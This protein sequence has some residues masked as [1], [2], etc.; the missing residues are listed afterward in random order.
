MTAEQKIAELL[1]R[2]E[3]LSPP[4]NVRFLLK[5][6]ADVERTLIPSNISNA[7]GL[8]YRKSSSSRPSVILNTRNHNS[9][10]ERFT[11]AH[12]LGHIILPWQTGT[13]YC[14]TDDSLPN[15]DLLYRD[16]EFEANRFAGELLVPV[17]WAL[18]VITRSDSL[19]EG[20]TKAAQR[21]DVSLLVATFSI[22]GALEN[23]VTYVTRNGETVLNLIG[24]GLG[25]W[26][27]KNWSEALGR[28][29]ASHGMQC[30]KADFGAYTL[31]C[32]AFAKKIARRRPSLSSVEILESIVGKISIGEEHRKLI[33]QVNGVIG[34][35]NVQTGSHTPQGI[36]VTLWFRFMDRPQLAQIVSHSLFDDFLS[37]K[38]Y[39]LAERKA[40]IK[41]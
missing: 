4:V 14:H 10:R 40:S 29:Y 19:A 9:N 20:I 25:K 11:M 13:I 35:A 41:K 39:E 17:D 32:V 8:V 28:E 33:W 3:K 18:N 1:L 26:S 7:D 5:K 27:S 22:T 6:Y 2:R 12:E 38:S 23:V 37:A 30:T 34:S 21:A 36:F 24:S 15:H 31:H 16:L